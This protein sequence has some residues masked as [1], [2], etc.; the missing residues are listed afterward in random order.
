MKNPWEQNV[1]MGQVRDWDILVKIPVQVSTG[2]FDQ[3]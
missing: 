2:Y 1:V 3:R